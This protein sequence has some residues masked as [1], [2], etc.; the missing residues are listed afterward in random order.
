MRAFELELID[1][2]ERYSTTSKSYAI[3]KVQYFKA[4][5]TRSARI[6]QILKTAS[7]ELQSQC[8]GTLS[9]DFFVCKSYVSRYIRSEN[10]KYY[11]IITQTKLKRVR[12]EIR[13]TRKYLAVTFPVP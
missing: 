4:L 13:K 12:K 3:L 2:F 7:F 8:Y 9:L 6:M 5:V 11:K 1:C 10:H